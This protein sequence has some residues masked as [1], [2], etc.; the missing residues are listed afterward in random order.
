M[1]LDARLLAQKLAGVSRE[2]SCALWSSPA[3]FENEEFD[4]RWQA[5]VTEGVDP[6]NLWLQW[7]TIRGGRVVLGDGS[8]DEL[9]LGDDGMVFLGGGMLRKTSGDRMCR[10][11]K[12]GV[13]I[14]FVRCDD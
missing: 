14:T 11:G 12:S 5:S 4:G 3:A 13:S 9:R 1:S 8:V 7:F 6:P 2:R 10:M